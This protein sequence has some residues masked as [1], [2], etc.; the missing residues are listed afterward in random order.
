MKKDRSTRVAEALLAEVANPARPLA[1]HTEVDML[2]ELVLLGVHPARVRLP[3]DGSLRIDDDDLVICPDTGYWYL[4]SGPARE[5][6]PL[7]NLGDLRDA[8]ALITGGAR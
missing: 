5:C 2:A 6:G 4:A 8:L 3:G 7:D 1:D